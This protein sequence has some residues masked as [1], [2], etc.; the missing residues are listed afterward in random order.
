MT[1]ALELGLIILV[2][3]INKKYMDL[4]TTTPPTNL[5]DNLQFN[6][7]LLIKS[8]ITAV[9]DV[10]GEDMTLSN[11]KYSE[12]YNPLAIFNILGF[13]LIFTFIIIY[14]GMTR[15]R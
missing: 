10:I 13:I 12:Q 9:Y 3:N 2:I 11:I 8:E 15:N 5:S 4:A 6:N 14:Y 7:N 1:R